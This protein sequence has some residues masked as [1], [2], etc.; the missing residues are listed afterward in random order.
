MNKAKGVVVKRIKIAMGIGLLTVVAGCLG[1]VDGGYGGPV[2][3]AEPD[4]FLF[5]GG[6]YGGGHYERGR[7][8]HAYSQRGAGS[9]AAAHPASGGR[10]RDH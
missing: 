3:V 6:F 7:D 1:Y 4:V 8:V 2:V 10:G 9:R 5:G